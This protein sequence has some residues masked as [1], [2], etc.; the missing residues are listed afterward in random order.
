MILSSPLQFNNSHYLLRPQGLINQHFPK[1]KHLILTTFTIAAVVAKFAT[2]A[3]RSS[4]PS[5][6][7]FFKILSQIKY[8]QIKYLKYWLKPALFELPKIL[9]QLLIVIYCI[10]G[11]STQLVNKL[12]PNQ[13][14]KPEGL[15]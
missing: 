5:I 4:S 1:S 3:S 10:K 9:D 7:V 11:V 13:S 12:P 2:T 6:K 15:P 8:L 14:P